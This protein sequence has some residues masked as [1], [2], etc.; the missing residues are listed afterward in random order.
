MTTKIC[1]VRHNR[2]L[3]AVL[4][5][6]C[7]LYGFYTLCRASG[8]N[9]LMGSRSRPS[10][11]K[12]ITVGERTKDLG[13]LVRGEYRSVQFQLTNISQQPIK[14]N[15][16]IASCTC[17]NARLSRDSLRPGES[18]DVSVDFAPGAKANGG[19]R[20]TIEVRYQ[21][22]QGQSESVVLEILAEVV[23]HYASPE[24]VD[25]RGDE[26]S[27]RFD[28]VLVNGPPF[29]ILDVAFSDPELTATV[30]DDEVTQSSP[31]TIQLNRANKNRDTFLAMASVRTDSRVSEIVKVKVNCIALTPNERHER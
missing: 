23:P 22:G 1:T 10:E 9:E 20:S 12:A 28:I 25:I 31:A 3:L 6:S 14:L 16:P 5:I 11:F 24:Y 2:L 18:V 19:S 30:V 29:K 4:S 26:S 17:T 21:V 15:D 13:R 8:I 27:S 7:I